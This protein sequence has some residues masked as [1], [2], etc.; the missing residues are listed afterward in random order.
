MAMGDLESGLDSADIGLFG[1]A[2]FIYFVAD[3]VR[4]TD[5]RLMIDD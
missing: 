4:R 1:D 2:S 3:T 5:F